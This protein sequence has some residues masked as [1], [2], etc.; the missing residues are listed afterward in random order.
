M[1]ACWVCPQFFH[2]SRKM[3]ALEHICLVWLYVWSFLKKNQCSWGV[4]CVYCLKFDMV[5]ECIAFIFGC[6]GYT[7]SY[8]ISLSDLTN[9]VFVWFLV[10]ARSH[11]CMPA[12][13]MAVVL[14]HLFV[15]SFNLYCRVLIDTLTPYTSTTSQGYSRFLTGCYLP[16]HLCWWHRIREE[17]TPLS[18]LHKISFGLSWIVVLGWLVY[19]WS[20]CAT[21]AILGL[22]VYWFL[23][24][25]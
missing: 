12:I 8:R 19:L 4:Y 20:N 7:W 14:A 10:V 18:I 9:L 23:L 15:F 16:Y 22:G 21:M 3:V 2:Y 13:D 5:D 1:T 6:I 17:H 24:I 25:T 11:D